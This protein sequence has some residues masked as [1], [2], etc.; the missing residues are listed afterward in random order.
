M[1]KTIF[2]IRIFFFGVCLLGSW[3]ITLTSDDYDVGKVL[4]FGGCL[5]ALV[6]LVD[7]YLK[8][9]SLRGLSA[10]TFGPKIFGTVD[11]QHILH[12]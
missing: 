3:L 1:Q 2:I 7:I 9:F 11:Q 10:V 12:G 4:F 6:I 8:G 5:G